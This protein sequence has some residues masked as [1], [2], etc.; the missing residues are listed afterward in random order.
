MSLAL[1]GGAAI[2]P[3]ED[4]VTESCAPAGP[5]GLVCPRSCCAGTLPGSFRFTCSVFLPLLTSGAAKAEPP[6]AGR[7]PSENW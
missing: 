4:A 3:P 7:A 2:L 5:G 6:T 1:A